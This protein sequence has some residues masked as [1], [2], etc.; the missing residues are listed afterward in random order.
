M[1]LP[2]LPGI[3]LQSGLFN[4]IIA[5]EETI[6][7]G[8]NDNPVIERYTTLFISGNFSRILDGINR[9]STNF[10]IQRA[11]TV[12][13]LLTILHETYH[14]IV[15]LEHDPTIYDDAGQV[16]TMIPRALKEI[17]HDKIV[18]L[19]TTKM[20]RHFSFLISNA[21]RIYSIGTSNESGRSRRGHLIE[22]KNHKISDY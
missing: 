9:R 8:L 3:I 15:F 13:Q 17:S 16:K 12:H 21:D 1:D 2:I 20:D 10:N 22:H 11:F 4:A 14:T 5:P 19:Y 7:A 18:V 6:L